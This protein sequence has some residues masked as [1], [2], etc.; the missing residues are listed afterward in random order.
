MTSKKTLVLGAS[1]KPNRYSNM[2]I[3]RLI[4]N[5]IP[6]V[7]IGLREGIIEGVAILT[8]KKPLEDI[9]TVTL[10]LNAQRQKEYYQYILD[11]KPERIIFNPGTA[12]PEFEEILKKENISFEHACTLVMLTCNQF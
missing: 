10:Y 4:E 6:T 12:N 2:A 5:K 7:A 9:H 8:E 11:L 1:L 3:K